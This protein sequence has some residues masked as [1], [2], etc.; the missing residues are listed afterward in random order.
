MRNL[1]FKFTTVTLFFVF[2]LNSCRKNDEIQE[3][4]SVEFVARSLYIELTNHHLLNKV[5]LN[6]E[7]QLIPKTV[8][9]DTVNFQ[10]TK[11]VVIDFGKGFGCSDGLIRRGKLQIQQTTYNQEKKHYQLSTTWLD[12]FGVYLNNKW[13]YLQGSSEHIFQSN[14]YSTLKSQSLFTNSE[15]TTTIICDSLK[16]E[17]IWET[18]SKTI[19]GDY[20][21]E[22]SGIIDGVDF[23]LDAQVKANDYLF[24]LHSGEMNWNKWV[25]DFDPYRNSTIDDWVKILKGANEYFF[26]LR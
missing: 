20:I 13:Y 24:C 7:S 15:F 18:N 9:I 16:F 2:V 6:L 23:I 19:V 5:N 26:H 17:D 8:N 10:A 25:Y 4:D 21:I 22:G 11:V 14:G 12:S 3:V 1:C